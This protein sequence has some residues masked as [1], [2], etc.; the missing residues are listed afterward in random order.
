MERKIYEPTEKQLAKWD[1]LQ[2]A[3]M[4]TDEEFKASWKK[5]HHGKETGWGMGKRDW[6]NIHSDDQLTQT[7]TYNQGLWQGRIDAMLGLEP[8]DT[9]HYHTDPYEYGYYIG[10]NGFESFWSGY[11]AQARKNLAD[12]YKGE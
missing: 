5:S 11:D 6:I 2:P 1:M 12:Q 10:Y 4:P 9:P 8:L 7:V 3:D